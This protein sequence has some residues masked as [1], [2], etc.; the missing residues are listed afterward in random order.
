MRLKDIKPNPD[1]PRVLRDD[2]FQKLKQSIT[3]F[4]KMLA[5]RPLVIDENKFKNIGGDNVSLLY[6]KKN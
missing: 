1:N 5:L 2:K 3:E 4:P 6:G